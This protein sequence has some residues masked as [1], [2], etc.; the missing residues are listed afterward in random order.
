MKSR[1]T[2]AAWPFAHFAAGMPVTV[3]FSGASSALTR[4]SVF[5]STALL[6]RG[7]CLSKCLLRL[8]GSSY[9]QTFDVER[10][11]SDPDRHALALLAAGADAR[12][13]LEVAPD[14]GN[15]GQGVRA[16]SDQCRAFYG[17]RDLAVFDEIGLGGREH[18]LAAR[19]VD[20]AAAEI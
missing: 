2:G 13:E 20:L 15:A 8:C 5:I 16:V 18:E 12:I 11:L 7:Q 10:R 4:S 6:Q 3:S 14:H 17:V 19:N 9:R 1:S